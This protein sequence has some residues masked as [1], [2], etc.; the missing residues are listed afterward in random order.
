MTKKPPSAINKGI[1]SDDLSYI[2]LAKKNI[3]YGIYSDK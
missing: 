1:N 2:R 3:F